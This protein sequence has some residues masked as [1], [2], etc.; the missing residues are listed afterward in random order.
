MSATDI[1]QNQQDEVEEKPAEVEQSP[2]PTPDP[3][4]ISPSMPSI[5][6]KLVIGG[7]NKSPSQASMI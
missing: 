5:S 3:L 6:K 7:L 4:S 2:Q 1:I